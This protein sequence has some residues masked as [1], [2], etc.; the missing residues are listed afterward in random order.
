MTGG[1]RPPHCDVQP[2]PCLICCGTHSHDGLLIPQPETAMLI[3][4]GT[5]SHDG[6]LNPQPETAWPLEIT[7]IWRQQQQMLLSALLVDACTLS[8]IRRNQPHHI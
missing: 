1:L 2:P 3:R 4:W 5:H 6:I 8:R 7:A